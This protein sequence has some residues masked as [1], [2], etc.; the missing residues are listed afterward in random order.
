MWST[1]HDFARAHLHFFFARTQREFP[2][3]IAY[4]VSKKGQFE[5][6]QVCLWFRV[7]ILSR[8]ATAASTWFWTKPIPRLI[9]SPDPFFFHFIFCWKRVGGRWSARKPLLKTQEVFECVAVRPVDGPSGKGPKDFPIKNSLK[10]HYNKNNKYIWEKARWVFSAM[11]RRFRMG[12]SHTQKPKNQSLRRSVV[13]RRRKRL[14]EQ[15]NDWWGVSD[16]THTHTQGGFPN[17]SW[18][19]RRR[20]NNNI[21]LS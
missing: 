19:E 6:L 7:F 13:I 10:Q 16:Y 14:I 20:R 18:G 21:S 11:K 4:I 2:Y 5:F 12:E 1:G 3:K 15:K 9:Y 17:F 8:I